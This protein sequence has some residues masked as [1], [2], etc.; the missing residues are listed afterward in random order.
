MSIFFGCLDSSYNQN[1]KLQLQ[2]IVPFWPLRYNN[3]FQSLGEM[4]ASGVNKPCISCEDLRDRQGLP[5]GA[6]SQGC[7]VHGKRCRW[8]KAAETGELS[9]GFEGPEAIDLPRN[10][11][12]Q[13]R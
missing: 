5:T 11:A 2:E 12:I 8:D 9:G 4:V 10:L 13:L 6:Q 7:R 1:P 3:G